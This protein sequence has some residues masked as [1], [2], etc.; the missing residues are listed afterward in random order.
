MAQENAPAGGEDTGGGWSFQ[1]V[2]IGSVLTLIGLIVLLFVV[3]LVIALTTDAAEAAS[4]MSYLRDLVS[5]V[6]S[7]QIIL[8]IAGVGVLI[9]QVARFVNL[10]RSEVKPITED[11]KQMLTTA[12]T[13]GAFVAK[14]T[15]EPIIKTQSFFAGLFTF[16]R[17]IVRLGRI[18]KRA[19]EKPADAP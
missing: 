1:R 19:P 17:E 8:V 18:L 9:F 7:V 4:R 2:M 5:I 11:A 10:L 14:H 13:T 12:R 15:T 3:A 6:L 16:L